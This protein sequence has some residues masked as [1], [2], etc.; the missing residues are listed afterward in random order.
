MLLILLKTS[1]VLF[2][3]E[4]PNQLVKLLL[5]M[6]ALSSL[7]LSWREKI[8]IELVF[9]LVGAK[10]KT[11]KSARASSNKTKSKSFPMQEKYQPHGHGSITFSLT[12]SE[13]VI[14]LHSILT[15]THSLIS[16]LLE[17]IT[18]VVPIVI[19]WTNLSILVEKVETRLLIMI[20]MVFL[21]SIPKLDIL[22][23]VISAQNRQD[24]V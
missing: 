23:N 20:V 22:T 6:L 4:L 9:Q 12:S 2:L 19:K 13:T 11:A 14:Y 21:V 15:M 16:Q 1:F 24:S 8:Q 17:D 5:I 10:T 7:M 3:M 18:G